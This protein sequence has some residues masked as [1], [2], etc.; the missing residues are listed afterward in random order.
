[1]AALP[2]IFEELR[3]QLNAQAE[4]R[5]VELEV[6]KDVPRVAVEGLVCMLALTNVVTNAIKYSDPAKDRRWVRVEADLVQ[7]EESPFVEVVVHDDLDSRESEGT[8][9]KVLMR[10]IDAESIA[11]TAG[12]DRPE[13][14]MDRSVRMALDPYSLPPEKNQ[15]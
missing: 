6:A 4:L 1:M 12:G 9:V 2:Q 7:G 13:S 10:A 5:D 11:R 3:S 15:P 14:L 8:T